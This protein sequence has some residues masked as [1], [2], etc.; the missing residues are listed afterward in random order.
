MKRPGRLPGLAASSC[1]SIRGQGKRLP[2][3]WRLRRI[4]QGRGGRQGRPRMDRPS[5]PIRRLQERVFR[6]LAVSHGETPCGASS[7]PNRPIY[8][9]L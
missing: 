2:P 9:T 6:A 3:I 7:A 8:G 1:L 4:R 5:F